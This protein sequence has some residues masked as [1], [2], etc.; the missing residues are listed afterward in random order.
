MT[1]E[2]RDER[3]ERLCQLHYNARIDWLE[4]HGPSVLVQLGVPRWEDGDEDVPWK[5]AERTAMRKLMDELEKGEQ[6]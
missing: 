2:Q 1:G 3:I 5:R 4:E 6:K